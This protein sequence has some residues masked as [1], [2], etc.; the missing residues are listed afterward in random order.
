MLERMKITVVSFL[1]NLGGFF[2]RKKKWLIILI[3]LIGI[4]LYVKQFFFNP[5]NGSQSVT[6]KRDSIKQELTLSGKIEAEE[7][8]NLQF[9]TGGQLVWVGVKEGDYVTKYQ[10]IA[11]LDKRQMQKTLDKYLNDYMKSRMI[12]DQKKADYS[13]GTISDAGNRVI[14]QYQSDLNKTVLDVEIEDIIMKLATLVSPIEGI[15]TKVKMPNV[16]TNFYLPGDAQF[17]I[18]N[19]LTVYLEVNADQTEVIDL[20][21]GKSGSIVFDSYTEEKIEGIIKSISFTPNTDES[22]TVYTV[23]V[24]LTNINNSDYKYRIGMTGDVNFT[25]KEKDSVLIIPLTF[26]KSDNKG[27]YVLVGREK[28]KTYVKTGIEN[29]LDVEITEGVIEGDIIYD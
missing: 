16:G 4:G 3:I 23:K 20:K 25:L 24:L 9:Q 17:E 7:D 19:P 1:K 11:A 22:G 10:S 28:K 6:V 8:V 21:E 2:A 13:T 14:T 27:K 12:F 26:L 5:K 15:I 29:E 18:V